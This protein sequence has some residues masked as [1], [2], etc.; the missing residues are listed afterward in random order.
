MMSS[1][2]PEELIQKDVVKM[3]TATLKAP[4]TKVTHAQDIAH[5]I[6]RKTKSDA[7]SQTIQL[8][9]VLFLHCV[10]QNRLII[11]ENIAI[12]NN[13]H[14]SVIRIVSNCVLDTKT[15]LDAT[16]PMNAY[17]TVS[18]PAQFNVPMMKSNAKV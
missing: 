4:I 14:S 10:F 3:I 9:V 5:L 6:A 17:Q 2:V 16:L 13:V 8:Q 18:K 12:I 1:C 7:P 15:T 11:T